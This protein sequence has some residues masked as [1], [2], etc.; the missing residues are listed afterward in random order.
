MEISLE[1]KLNSQVVQ[2]AWQDTQFMKEL[3]ANPIGSIEKLTGHK[4]SLPEG[5]KLV[6]VDQSDASTVY[7]NVPRKMDVDSLELTEEQLEQVAGGILPLILY[8]VCVGIAIYAA[9]HQ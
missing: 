6:V 9:S 2:K 5:Q 8:G 1:Q 3:V 7:F 4:I